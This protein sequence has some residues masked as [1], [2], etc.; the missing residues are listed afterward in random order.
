M[1]LSLGTTSVP[2]IPV[3]EAPR[4][5]S[6]AAV[7]PTP[8]PARSMLVAAQLAQNLLMPTSL[9]QVQ[10]M[11]IFVSRR[12]VPPARYTGP[13]REE[14]RRGEFLRRVKVAKSEATGQQTQ[15]RS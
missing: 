13:D 5:S 2:S 9:A 6:Q 14:K 4:A 8:I 11:S 10:V 12:L 3:M 1:D 15:S 7:A